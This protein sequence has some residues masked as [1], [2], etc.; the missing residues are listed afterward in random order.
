MRRFYLFPRNGIYYAQLVDPE[1]NR[2]LSARSTGTKTRDEAVL[3]VDSW[4]RGGIPLPGLGTRRRAAR[5]FFSVQRLFDKLQTMELTQEAVSR[6]VEILTSRGLQKSAT[7]TQSI[8]D[9]LFEDFLPSF[10]DF[11]HSEYVAQKRAHGLKIRR[12]HCN[13]S[14]WRARKYWF[15]FF[16]GSPVH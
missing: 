15:P 10:W 14:T 4:L 9:V 11:D 3:V 8:G 16:R 1:S 13:T 5:A 2:R 12:P 6:I 7:V